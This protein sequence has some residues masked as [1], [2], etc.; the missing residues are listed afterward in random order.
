MLLAR[1]STSKVLP[2]ALQ[3]LVEQTVAACVQPGAA[4]RG[5]LDTYCSLEAV[6]D[7]IS[8]NEA[9]ALLG[10][11]DIQLAEAFMSGN[12]IGVKTRR[13]G[14]AVRAGV[15]AAAAELAAVDLCGHALPADTPSKANS[16]VKRR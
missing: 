13:V 2:I 11:Q 4:S 3:Q 10:L 14:R 16:S 12:V 15:A 5:M 7:C 1:P 9:V 6:V 8:S